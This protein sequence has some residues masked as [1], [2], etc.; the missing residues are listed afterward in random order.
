LAEAEKH[1]VSP[2][3]SDSYAYAREVI[4]NKPAEDEEDEIPSNIPK[5]LSK[6]DQEKFVTGS[7]IYHREGYCVTC[8][9]ENGQGLPDSG[10]PPLAGTKWVTG[11]TDR[12]IKLTLKG[13][14]GPIEVMGKKYPGQ[15]PMTPFEHMLTD[16]EIAAVLTFVRNS[17]GNK[18]S[19]ISTEQVAKIREQK[20]SFIGLYSP[21]DLLKEHP[22]DLKSRK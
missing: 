14:M 17:Y 18:S 7:E 4:N 1:P 8:H 3:Y 19:S 22:M 15:V 11:N 13:L 12:L 6:A 16:K 10:F 20:K 21:E 2:L 5:Y 9:Q